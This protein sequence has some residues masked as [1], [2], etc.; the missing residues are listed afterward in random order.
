MKSTDKY[1]YLLNWPFLVALLVLL[2]NDHWWKWT[3]S[4]GLTGKLSDVAGLVLLPLFL[5]AIKPSWWRFFLL[6]SALS[7]CFWK[8]PYSQ[9][10]IDGYNQ[11]AWIPIQR[12][13]DYTDL[14]ALWVLPLVG[15]FIR[16][17]PKQQSWQLGRSSRVAGALGV[18]CLLAFSAT[19]PPPSFYY[20]ISNADLRFQKGTLRI[21]HPTEVVIQK[22]QVAGVPVE[23]DET[24]DKGQIYHSRIADHDSTFFRVPEWPLETDTIRNLQFSIESL[25][26]DRSKLYLNGMDIRPVSRSPQMYSAL[27]RRYRKQVLDYFREVLK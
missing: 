9:S 14:W 20:R 10:L 23:L 1:Q 8:S 24:L 5:C 11:L 17:L 25:T 4:N 26:K 3:F 12:V 18:V 2:L 21:K 16:E 7:F 22:L 13:V 6:I 27:E 19:S 15:W